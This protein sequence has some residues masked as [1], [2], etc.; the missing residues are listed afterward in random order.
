MRNVV[1]LLLII[2]SVLFVS[3]CSFHI[4][5]SKSENISVDAPLS[6]FILGR[7]KYEGYGNSDRSV[8]YTFVDDKI[9]KIWTGYDGGTCVYNFT[10]PEVISIDCSPRMIEQMKWSLKRDG[11]FL[12]IQRLDTEELKGSEQLKFERVVDK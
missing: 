9:I 11:Q 7:W 3:D 2:F 1:R 8:E 12:L 6:E 5:Q 4:G 10:E